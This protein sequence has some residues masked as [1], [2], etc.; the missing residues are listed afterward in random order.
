MNSQNQA[1]WEPGEAVRRPVPGRQV[2]RRRRPLVE[3]R[4]SSSA[5][6]DGSRD[7]P[8]NVDG[9]QT[10]TGY[11]VR[12]W[13]AG[14]IVAE[15]DANG[16]LYLVFSDN[17]NGIH[18]SDHPVTNSDVFVVS[19]TNGGSDWTTPTPVDAGRGRPV[20]PVGRR[21]PGQ[22]EA[23]RALPRPR[24]LERPDL[25]DRARRGPAGLVRED[26]GQHRSRRT[27]RCRSS[28]RPATPACEFC[29]VFHGDYIGLAYGSDG[30]ANAT[31]TDMRDPSPFTP[32]LFLQFIYYA[33][34]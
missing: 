8:I 21:Q 23:R 9:R 29:A 33:R 22:R 20:V 10:L 27:R 17:R 2:D 26:D 32:G 6:E 14:N 31:W 19:S 15:P 30:H 13:G 7:Y 11:Q 18:D 5:L 1:L 25:H 16:R 34:R 24:Q 28:S 3:R 4:A 12:V